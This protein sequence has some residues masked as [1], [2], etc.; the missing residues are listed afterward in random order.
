MSLASLPDGY[1]AAVFGASGGIGQALV[2]ALDRDPRC[3]GIHAGSRHTIT[4]PSPRISGFR[5]DLADEASISAAAD[6]IGPP[7]LVIVATGTLHGP[8]LTPEK[9]LRALESSGLQQAFAINAIGPALIARH[10]LPRLPRARRTLFAALSAKVGSIS[11][12]RLGGWHSYRASK[13]ALNMLVRTI[14]IELTRTHPETVCVALH[15]G[16]VDT[17][18]SKP[19]QT[20]VASERRFPPETSANH[21][22][23]VL[24]KL[25]P[26]NSG[27]LFGWDGQEITP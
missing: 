21:L 8:G 4:H 20:G 12:N 22:L 10:L 14:A 17:P 9:S 11:D 27:R 6:Q 23:S 7:D 3:A 1:R 19:F 2:A 24:D 18:L 26:E 5:F 25:R 15:P 16:T 13:A